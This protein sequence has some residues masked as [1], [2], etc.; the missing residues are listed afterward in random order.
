MGFVSVVGRFVVLSL[1]GSFVG[2]FVLSTGRS[3]V[4]RGDGVV[5]E[6][7]CVHWEGGGWVGGKVRS[8]VH[9]FYWVVRSFVCPSFWWLVGSS[10]RFC[11]PVGRLAFGR[12]LFVFFVG[13]TVTLNQE[14]ANYG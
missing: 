6:F 11:G 10:Y 8:F 13:R 5:R 3:S 9:S 1:A 7:I 4:R 12:Y 14:G 2:L